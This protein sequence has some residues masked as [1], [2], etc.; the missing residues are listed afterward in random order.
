MQVGPRPPPKDTDS[1]KVRGA[2]Q[3]G[4]LLIMPVVCED[5]TLVL[6]S[7]GWQSFSVPLAAGSSPAAGVPVKIQGV[8][9]EPEHGGGVTRGS[10]SSDQQSWAWLNASDM[11]N[12]AA[13]ALGELLRKPLHP[14]ELVVDALEPATPA[15]AAAGWPLQR[16][17]S[18]YV[19][20]HTM[21]ETHVAYMVT[22][23]SLAV[24]GTFMTWRRFRPSKASRARA[25]AVRAMSQQKRT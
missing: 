21:P 17:V 22:W 4:A 6:V 3:R 12:H 1:A 15:D 20:F 23:Y 16:P 7:R 5:G 18:S 8:L 25:H 19:G 2:Q 24:L 10:G 14:A 13:A 9:R 11:A